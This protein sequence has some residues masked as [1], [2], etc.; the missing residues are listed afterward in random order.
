MA[1]IHAVSRGDGS[2]R[3]QT[4]RTLAAGDGATPCRNRAGADGGES[5]GDVARGA[6]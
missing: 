5:A 2:A 6:V 1:A 3:V 4:G